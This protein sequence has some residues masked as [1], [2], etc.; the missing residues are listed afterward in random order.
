MKTF[1]R[2]LLA[3]LLAWLAAVPAFAR[4]PAPPVVEGRDYVVIANGTPF[5]PTK[6]KI[7]V[8]EVFGYWCHFCN[9]FQPLVDAWKRRLPADVNFVYVPAAF[10]PDDAYA[11]GFFAAQ[12]LGLLPRTHNALFRA[13]H[14]TRDMPMNASATEV[15]SFYA[16]YGVSAER[17]A[18]AMAAPAVDAQM[19]RARTFAERAQVPGTPSLIVAGRYRVTARTLDAQ[20]RIADALIAQ[21]R[22]R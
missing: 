17:F 1:P 9:D 13:I 22:G 12:Q 5:A 11:R 16:G 19:Q 7:E 6:G 14:A 4:T 2:L 8:A 10:N 18:A 21:L 15:A 20:L 3:C